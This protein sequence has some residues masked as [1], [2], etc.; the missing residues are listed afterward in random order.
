[1]LTFENK[2]LSELLFYLFPFSVYILGWSVWAD[3]CLL[4]GAEDPNKES[5]LGE[6]LTRK[7][8]EGVN[9]LNDYSYS[10][11]CVKTLD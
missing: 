1:M 11:I 5:H 2:F 3:L 9:V 7:A 10:V 4:R 6:L 8:D